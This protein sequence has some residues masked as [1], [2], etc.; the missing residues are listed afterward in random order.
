MK[1]ATERDM[2]KYNKKYMHEFEH[3]NPTE[4]LRELDRLEEREISKNRVCATERKV[5]DVI[6]NGKDGIDYEFN[7]LGKQDVDVSKIDSPNIGPEDF[8][9]HSVKEM[10]EYISQ[11]SLKRDIKK[12]KLV[13]FGDRYY[14]SD[15]GRHR[16]FMAKHMAL[17]K[18]TAHVDEF[19]ILE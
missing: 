17:D 14:V 19:K 11:G 15:G 1:D 16:I 3:L 13:K 6:E 8:K 2:E 9:K 4:R 10:E 5:L 18:I 7:S 12:P